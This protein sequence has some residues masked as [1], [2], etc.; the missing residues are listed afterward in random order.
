[1]DKEKKRHSLWYIISALLLI[2]GVGAIF[3]FCFPLKNY[4]IEAPGSAEPLTEM[5]TVNGKKE[6]A[7]G[8]FYLTTVMLRQATPYLYLEAKKDPYMQ[9]M[10][11]E[12]VMGKDTDSKEYDQMQQYY[13][14]TSQ[15]IAKKVALSLAKKP[16][17]L[18]YDGIY[19]L[20]VEKDSDFYHKLAV[21]DWITKINQKSFSSADEMIRYLQK[22]KAGTKVTLTVKKEGKEKE[23]TGVLK[24]I[25]ATKKVGLGIGL[26]TKTKIE[27]PEKIKFTVGDIGGPSAGMMFTLQIYELLTHKDLQKGRKIAGTGEIYPDGTIGRIGGIQD[28]IVAAD[29]SGAEIFLAPDDTWPKELGKK[30]K[31]FQSNYAEAKKTAKDIHTKMKVVPVKTVQDAI[32]YLEKSN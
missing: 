20:D 13:M 25:K 26:V 6:K 12:E 22:Q 10:K 8:D 5:V 1:M 24:K 16:Y 30:P 19:V 27:T 3:F 2:V 14:E 7:K 9:V 23:I 17:H 32:H 29:A 18:K 31:D 15:N 4:V 28:K 21:G 11:K